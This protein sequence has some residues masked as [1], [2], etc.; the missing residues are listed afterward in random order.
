[1]NQSAALVWHGLSE[2]LAIDEI[3]VRL[4]D[5]FDVD[6]KNAVSD[7]RASIAQLSGLGFLVD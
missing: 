3:A 4:T 5:A 7:V 2:G 1:L 6:H